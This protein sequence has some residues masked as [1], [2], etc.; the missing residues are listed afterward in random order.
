MADKREE[1]IEWAATRLL[2]DGL[3]DGSIASADLGEALGF[4]D[5]ATRDPRP[6]G[7]EL[8][9]DAFRIEMTDRILG[10]RYG[11]EIEEALEYS[12]ARA[13][14]RENDYL[15]AVASAAGV[16]SER[17]MQ[18]LGEADAGFPDELRR[19]TVDYFYC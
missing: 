5:L 11:L 6:H 2:F 1:P 18:A 8:A 12:R 17:M 13:A 9:R 16:S 14:A 7:S 10:A 3:D 19:M 4:V 15:N